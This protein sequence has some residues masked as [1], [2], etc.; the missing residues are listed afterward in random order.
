MEDNKVPGENHQPAASHRQTLSYNVV[1]STLARAGFEL[2]TLVVIAQ[3]VVISTTIR[4]HPRLPPRKEIVLKKLYYIIKH[5]I[6]HCIFL[7]I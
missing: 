5:R 6:G 7:D 3:V 2:P 4:S 1:S